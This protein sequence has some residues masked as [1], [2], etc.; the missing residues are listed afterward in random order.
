MIA[1]FNEAERHFK[2]L[3]HDLPTEHR[4]VVRRLWRVAQSAFDFYVLCTEEQTKRP[5]RANRE[6]L[7][8][9][10]TE[11]KAA[12]AMVTNHFVWAKLWC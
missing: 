12:L 6:K 5:S 10:E 7:A 2:G 4:Q 11:L 3:C 8:T 9:A 1:E